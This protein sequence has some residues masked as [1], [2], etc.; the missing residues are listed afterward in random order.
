MVLSA[1]LQAIDN[2]ENLFDEMLR[3]GKRCVLSFA[4]FAFRDLRQMY[5]QQGRAPKMEGEYQY[6]WFN[7]PNRRFPSIADVEDFL[8]YKGATIHRS[9]YLDT[10]LGIVVAAEADPNL[11]ADTA[12]LVF[13]R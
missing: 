7:T 5:S 12:I 2:L 3:V 10:G 1:T 9:T 8:A 6:E 13:S 4:N 11:N